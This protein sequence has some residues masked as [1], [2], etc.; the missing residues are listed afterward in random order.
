[1]K[2][3]KLELYIVPVNITHERL[4]DVKMLSQDIEAGHLKSGRRGYSIIRQIFNYRKGKLGSVNV[5]F[6][7]P[8]SLDERFKVSKADS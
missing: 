5:Q 3:Q 8:I 7:T 4:F 6:G 1:M 2:K